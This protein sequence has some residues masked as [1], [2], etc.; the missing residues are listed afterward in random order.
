MRIAL[1]SSFRFAA[2]ATCAAGAMVP[3]AGAAGLDT[4]APTVTS[5]KL[6]GA[7]NASASQSFVTVNFKAK[8]D[9]SGVYDYAIT[10]ESPNKRTMIRQ[11]GLNPDLST[12]FSTA[13][14]V[15]YIR[16]ENI[17]FS[18][19]FNRW[20]EPGV[21]SITE[22]MVRDVAG[23]ARVYDKAALAALGNT[24]FT[25]TN[26]SAD[27]AAPVL[28]NGVIETPTLSLSVQPA[29]TK[30]GTLPFARMSV[31]LQDSGT[32]TA[33]GVD[34]YSFYFCKLPFDPATQQCADAFGVLGITG[35]P[36]V[37]TATVKAN[38][39][40]ERANAPVMRTP[41]S[42]GV[43]HLCSI[44]VADIAGNH[45]TYHATLCGGADELSALFPGGT[46]VTVNP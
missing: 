26:T 20:S 16:Y 35:K 37:A 38:G 10:L 12:S 6:S 21:W 25:V 43:Y 40:L 15:G 29:G 2:L 45:G 36:I 7:V 44:D 39:M 5:F 3:H 24:E 30:A 41:V 19:V 13:V 27:L 22:L 46:T 23:N 32:P 4:K 17:E 31:T 1:P 42:T 34:T 14:Q 28:S 18:E 33:S 11:E 9:L 8:D